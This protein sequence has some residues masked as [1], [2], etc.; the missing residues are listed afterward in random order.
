LAQS[1]GRHRPDLHEFDAQF[2][3]TLQD[4]PSLQSGQLPPQSTSVSL[5]FITPSVQLGGAHWPF[6]H[7]AVTQ[8]PPNL[9][10]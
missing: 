5:P 9:H 10:A 1:R 3:G 8:S 6:M 4:C 7:C 2:G